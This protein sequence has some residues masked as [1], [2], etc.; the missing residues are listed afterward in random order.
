MKAFNSF[1]L[2]LG[3]LANSNGKDLK[4]SSSKE[5]HVDL[6]SQYGAELYTEI[7]IG[8]PPQ[9]FKT[10]IHLGHNEL[11]VPSSTCGA[12]NV[13]CKTH[14]QYDSGNS[15]THV[16][17]GSKFNVK[18][19]IGKASGFLSQDKVCVDGVCM[20]EQT[21]GEAT[22]ES[23]D[24]FANV[25]HDGVLGLGFGKDSF[26][27]SLLDQGR[28]ESPLF[29]LWVNRQPF[30]SKNNSRLVLGGIDTGHYSGNISY[31]PLNSDDVWRVG[32]KSISIKG[33]HRGCGFI[34][35]PGC[36]VVFD[37]GSRFTYG[38][39]LEAKTINRWI[40]ATQIAPSY[41]Y[42]KVRCNEILTLPNV[43]L[44]FEDLTLVLKPKDYIVE[45]KI[46]GMKTCM[47]GFV[48]LTKQ[49]SWTLGANFFGAYF[50]VY[51]IENKRI[52]LA[53]SRRAE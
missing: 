4:I 5:F 24:P 33:V 29:S 1:I 13:P 11:W 38:P 40:G 7:T 32:M 35:R 14:N 16:K 43:E 3:F 47:S 8:T 19:K 41:G 37:A 10:V 9:S 2:L 23:M 53:T 27:N 31:I 12:P 36:D 15:S 50:S 18:Y 20:E 28:I 46:L 6:L 42:Y 34:T 44:V 25:Y 48:G 51:D 26:L 30:R 17:D 49:E 39:I 52:G 22:S 21:F 45:T